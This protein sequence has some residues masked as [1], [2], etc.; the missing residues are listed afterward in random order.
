[1]RHVCAITVF[2]ILTGI[3]C[4][5]EDKFVD[6]SYLK[7][8]FSGITY[9]DEDG[10]IIG[11]VDETDWNFYDGPINLQYS[12]KNSGVDRLPPTRLDI[13]PAYPNPSAGPFKLLI[14]YNRDVTS[15]Y[16]QVY[17][18]DMM[19][20]YE[21]E[22]KSFLYSTK[23]L[24]PNKDL[25]GNTLPEGVYRVYYS[26]TLPGHLRTFSGHGDIMVVHGRD[27]WNPNP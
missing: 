23:V 24:I 3:G 27:W 19:L 21:C 22:I 1:M 12:L 8:G 11:P 25:F 17:N 15:G 5:N 20:I 4:S 6:V 16:V 9:T 13:R 10:D 26:V 7:D 2:V 18:N 14:L